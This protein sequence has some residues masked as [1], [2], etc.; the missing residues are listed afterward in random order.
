MGIGKFILTSLAAAAVMLVLATAWQFAL[1]GRFYAENMAVAREVRLYD[2]IALAYLVLGAMMAL[3][4]PSGYAGGSP[5][6][7]GARFGAMIGI[8]WS[9]PHSLIVYATQGTQS[10]T[11]VLAAAVWHAVEQGIGGV[12]IGIMHGRT[13]RLRT[14]GDDRATGIAPDSQTE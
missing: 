5:A 14:G 9:L 6:M 11:L 2:I 8:I 7:E 1:A 3:M 12:V 4:Y 13:L 10:T